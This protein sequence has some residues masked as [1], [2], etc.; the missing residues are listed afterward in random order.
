MHPLIEGVLKGCK[1]PFVGDPIDWLEKHFKIPFSARSKNFHRSQAPHLNDIIRAS[2]DLAHKKVVVRAC[3][4]AG[5][6]T[7]LEATCIFNVGIEWGPMLVVGQTD[8]DIKD[9]SES[10]YSSEI[11]ACEEIHQ[12]LP[13]DRHDRRKTEIMWKHMAQFFT[14]PNLS[15]LQAKS[16]R[17]CYGDETWI[18]ARGMIR[19]M[20]ARHHDRWNRKTILVS[21]GWESTSD[22]PHDMDAQYEEGDDRRRGF[23]CPK[24][25]RW[26]EYRW[27]QVK[28]EEIQIA[29]SSRIDFD[30]TGRTARYACEHPDCG[31][32]IADTAQER[33]A[34]AESGSYRAFNPHHM[35][36]VAS[37]QCPA[38]AVWWI[39]WAELAVEWIKANKAA[40]RGDTEPL[41]S[42]Q[43][44]RAAKVW[45]LDA[46][47]VTDDD[48]HRMRDTSYRRG[49]CPIEPCLVT[50]CADPG[51]RQTHWSVEAWSEMGESYVLDYGTT[52]SPDSLIGIARKLEYPIKGTD[53]AAKI[54]T[55]LIDSGDFTDEVYAVCSASEGI[56]WPSKGSGAQMGTWRASELKEYALLMLYTYVDYQAK[57]SLYINKIA[58]KIPPK[59]HFPGD[60]SEDFLLGHCGQRII[61]AERGRGKKWKKV[62]GDHFGDCSKLHIVCWWALREALQQESLPKRDI[63]KI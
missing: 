20:M 62:A 33:R 60:V 14:G 6:T 46:Q 57:V 47:K 37:F 26:Q 24:C 2:V 9:W 31:H 1:P 56:F 13:E 34:I 45:I 29:G 19:E 39:P 43:M 41:R 7:V 10:R 63:R 5:K 27:E 49:E 61:E 3:T 18:W 23:V 48:V 28:Y 35:Q 58:K 32:E 55:G 4:G 21:Q 59:L 53:R 40:K 44:K 38:W 25:D 11:D 51:E 22:D 54:E 36:G 15:G 52:L 12:Y 17:F 30:K 42:W 16:M 50:M 8:K